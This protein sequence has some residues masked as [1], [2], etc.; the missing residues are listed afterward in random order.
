ME[1]Y[2]KFDLFVK[3]EGV[4]TAILIPECCT[5]YRCEALKA[6]AKRAVG[7]ILLR[8]YICRYVEEKKRGI[9]PRWA[10]EIFKAP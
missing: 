2:G 4:T 7:A 6:L 3:A 8:R 5:K 9:P 10:A 1:D